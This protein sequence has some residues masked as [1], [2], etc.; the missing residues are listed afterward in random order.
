MYN[1]EAEGFALVT[2]PAAPPDVCLMFF[3]GKTLLERM[4]CIMRRVLVSLGEG[5]K[6]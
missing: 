3:V 5:K 1:N 4:D 2:R 6:L